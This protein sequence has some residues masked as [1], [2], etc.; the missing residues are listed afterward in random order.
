MQRRNFISN[1]AVILPAGMVAPKL[2]FEN[3]AAH[4][5]AIQ[6]KVLVLGAGNAGLF[7]AR[8]LKKQKIDAIVL[9]PSG[10]INQQAVFNHTEKA[11]VI[12]QADKH[13]KADV[14]TIRDKQ[15]S[16]VEEMVVFDFLPGQIKKTGTGFLVTN[17]THT[18]SAEK[19]VVALPV[20]MDTTEN[21]L[22]IC[23][24]QN[25]KTV[26]VSCKRKNQKNPV[27]L[28]TVP[29][30]RIDEQKVLQFASHQSQ[31]ILAIL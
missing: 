21:L 22:T 4:R 23:I 5:Q 16:E 20:Q 26:S 2:L 3:E 24:T 11:G 13:A 27:V 9:E 10:G 28:H 30:S 12:R 29:A 25:N 19:L 17:G 15:L 14:V 7:I 1:L 18:Y 8:Q 6:T 31:G